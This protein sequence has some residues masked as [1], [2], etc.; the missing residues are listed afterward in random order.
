MVKWNYFTTSF[1]IYLIGLKTRIKKCF[2]KT[3]SGK[4]GF[5]VKRNFEKDKNSEINIKRSF[6][7]LIFKPEEQTLWL[8]CKSVILTGKKEY[9]IRKEQ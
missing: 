9:R 2:W 8:S 7:I 6:F 1:T 3:F 4:S 5:N